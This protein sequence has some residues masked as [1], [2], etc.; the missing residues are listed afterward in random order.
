M[1][2][3]KVRSISKKTLPSEGSGGRATHDPNED[4]ALVSSR[5]AS[6]SHN[7]R[8][9]EDT[10]PGQRGMRSGSS[11]N[12]ASPGMPGSEYVAQP[13]ITVRAENPT[14]ARNADREKRTHIT[15]LITVEM[16]T[17]MERRPESLNMSPSVASP[18]SSHRSMDDGHE[19]DYHKRRNESRSNS[20]SHSEAEDTGYSYS[21][22]E[23]TQEY[24]SQKEASD[25]ST[26]QEEPFASVVKDLQTRMADWK[27]RKTC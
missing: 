1:D 11:A 12:G 9:S 16:P 4:D 8:G 3:H 27:G 15:C 24:H 25:S 21:A 7:R 18:L 6:S 22:T 14:V 19:D 17:R 20:V 13:S 26:G 10:I 2:S 23:P 5:Y